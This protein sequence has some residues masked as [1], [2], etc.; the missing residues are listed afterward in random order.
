MAV[1]ASV[2]RIVALALEEDLG[3][4]DITSIACVP[5][6][7]RARGII[8]AKQEGVLAGMGVVRE[9][10]RQMDEAICVEPKMGD[11]DRLSPG[12]VVASVVGP[13]RSVLA[14]ERTALNFLQQL[15]GVATLTRAFVDQVAGTRAC[16]VDTR[17][18]VPGLRALQKAAVRAGGGANHRFGLYDAILIKENHIALAGGVAEALK[19]AQAA[20]GFMVKVEVEVTTPQ[21]AET[22]AR[23][24]AD[25][26]LLDNMSLE[27]VKDSVRRIGGRALTEVSGGINLE[28]VRA[29]A[30]AGVDIISVGRLTHSAPAL[31]LSLEIG[32][33]A[34]T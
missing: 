24:G 11:G 12:A 3:H 4:G 26:I 23:L 2:S 30:E 18:T 9:V 14:F 19:A 1:P 17:K 31:D 16:I 29:Y 32:E 15:S 34:A 6:G 7:L 13:G 8:V 33:W 5:E 27:A 22:A 21:D 25:I 20:A 10:A 28:N